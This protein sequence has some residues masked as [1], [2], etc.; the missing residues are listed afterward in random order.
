[1]ATLIIVPTEFKPL[2]ASQIIGFDAGEKVNAGEAVYLD[3]NNLWRIATSG[4]TEAEAQAAG[5][6]AHN[7]NANAPLV[8]AAEGVVELGPNATGGI[9]G[10]AWYLSNFGAQLVNWEDL[11]STNYVTFFGVLLAN[12]QFFLQVAASGGQRA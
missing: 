8:V 6:A 4:N 11:S 1:M 3:A 10:S 5:F 2:S 12:D 7:V 9:V